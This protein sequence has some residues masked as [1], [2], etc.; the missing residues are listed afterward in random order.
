MGRNSL[1]SV[2]CDEIG[3]TVK[4]GD[5]IILEDWACREAVIVSIN[6]L[7]SCVDIDTSDT[8]LIWAECDEG[9]RWPCTINNITDEG[10][11]AETITLPGHDNFNPILALNKIINSL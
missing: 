10:I 2:T 5:R 7:D 4:V 1:Q 3:W 6:P 11:A 9:E 8:P